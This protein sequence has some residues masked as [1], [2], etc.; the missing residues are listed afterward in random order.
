MNIRIATDDNLL[1][2]AN[3]EIADLSRS[4]CMLAWAIRNYFRV[5]DKKVPRI[6]D[7]SEA[8]QAMR[9]ALAITEARGT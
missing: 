2:A 4:N 3:R 7:M 5:R 6:E 8:V 1:V 9:N